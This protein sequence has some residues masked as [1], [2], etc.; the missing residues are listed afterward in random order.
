MDPEKSA[1][2]P[3]CCVLSPGNRAD[4]DIANED[5]FEYEG[6][7]TTV[8]QSSSVPD[9]CA[10]VPRSGSRHGDGFQSTSRL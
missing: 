6:Q 3:F 7:E 1:E 8:A 9:L 2:A 10:L 5:T 4:E